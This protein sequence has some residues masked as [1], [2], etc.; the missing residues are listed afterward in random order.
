MTLVKPR[1]EWLALFVLEVEIAVTL[2]AENFRGAVHP[3]TFEALHPAEVRIMRIGMKRPGQSGNLFVAAVTFET[4]LDRSRRYRFVHLV[5][6]NALQPFRGMFAPD[7][8]LRLCRGNRQTRLKSYKQ[9]QT[10]Q[11]FFSH[12]QP[13]DLMIFADGF[14]SPGSQSARLPP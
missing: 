14:R 9:R 11:C 8:R 1:P 2:D 6:V 7:S 13:P 5:A 10:Q 4:E 12:A 3:V